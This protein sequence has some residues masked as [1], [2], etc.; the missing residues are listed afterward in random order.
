MNLPL[1][2]LNEGEHS[3]L[4]LVR[5]VNLVAGKL[6]ARPVEALGYTARRASRTVESVFPERY[7]F[8][9]PPFHKRRPN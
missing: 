8:N 1:E 3:N 7:K 5:L 9:R 4:T 2:F 6:L